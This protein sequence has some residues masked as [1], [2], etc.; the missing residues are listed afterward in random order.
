M[1]QLFEAQNNDFVTEYLSFGFSI[2]KVKTF[3][4]KSDLTK[5]LKGCLESEYCLVDSSNPIIDQFEENL[6]TD[7]N[8]ETLDL[9]LCEDFKQTFRSI[10]DAVKNDLLN[11][12]SSLML[13][14]ILQKETTEKIAISLPFAKLIPILNQIKLPF[15]KNL[16]IDNVKLNIFSANIYE[17]FSF[18]PDENFNHDSLG[19]L[20][21]N[22]L[23]KG[24]V[25]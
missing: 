3:W 15:N 5:F 11:N 10:F 7:L 4:L 17:A 2:S 6:L 24:L 20:D 13:A 18:L 14:Q 8:N 22:M 16:I 1:I 25:Q 23:L 21:V 12:L 19:G 9:I